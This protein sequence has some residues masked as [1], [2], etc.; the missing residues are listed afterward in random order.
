M[1]KTSLM[2]FISGVLTANLFAGDW[3]SHWEWPLISVRQ[4]YNVGEDVPCDMTEGSSTWKLKNSKTPND[5]TDTVE[6]SDPKFK[7]ENKVSTSEKK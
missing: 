1:K 7:E 2:L 4:V 5:K 3:A 6:L